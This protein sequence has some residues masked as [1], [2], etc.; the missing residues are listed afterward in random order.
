MDVLGVADY[1]SDKKIEK[2]KMADPKWRTLIFQLRFTV[3]ID[4]R[5]KLT[6]KNC[7]EYD[8]A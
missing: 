2:F 3:S 5:D 6:V 7:L 8:F 1:E 4:L